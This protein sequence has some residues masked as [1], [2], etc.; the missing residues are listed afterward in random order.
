M[1]TRPAI[2][3]SAG[4]VSL[5]CAFNQDSS[6]FSVGLD[7]GFCGTSSPYR[8]PSQSFRVLISA[9][10]LQLGAMQA[11][12][13]PRYDTLIANYCEFCTSCRPTLILNTY[14]LQCWYCNSINAGAKQLCCP[15]W[16][17]K[18]TKIPAEQGR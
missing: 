11:S 5:S 4:P 7:T 6:C 14:R 9:P 15:G 13:L 16:R 3:E 2:D 12:S 10:S 8:E 17:G 18:A 1:N